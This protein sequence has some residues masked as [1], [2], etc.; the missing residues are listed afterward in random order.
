MCK[1]IFLLAVFLHIWWL[2][3]WESTVWY[4]MTTCFTQN[5]HRHKTKFIRIILFSQFDL[6]LNIISKNWTG[7]NGLL[8]SNYRMHW[9]I[10]VT[11]IWFW[12]YWKRSFWEYGRDREYEP[13]E[14]RSDD[15]SDGKTSHSPPPGHQRASVFW[16]QWSFISENLLQSGNWWMWKCGCA[17]EDHASNWGEQ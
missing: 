9:N 2:I 10:N 16:T 3:P 13:V 12:S 14:V 4:T 6:L 5:D 11:V 1:Y 7:L 8:Q 15:G 17:G